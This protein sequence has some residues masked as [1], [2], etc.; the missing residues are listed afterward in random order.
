MGRAKRITLGGYAYHVLN[1]ANGRLRLFRK[2]G[3]FSAFE[4][5]L[6]EGLER[7]AMRICGYCI[8]T[9]HWHLL[10]WPCEDGDL[11]DYTINVPDTF[12][13]DW[14]AEES[15]AWD[16]SGELFSAC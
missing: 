7:V 16:A 5:I 12:N 2:Y 3:D 11:S 13:S 15:C 10:L 9:N 14:R 1:R 6:A 8:M 4:T